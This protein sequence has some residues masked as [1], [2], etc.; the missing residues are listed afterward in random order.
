MTSP[1][2]RQGTVIEFD[3]HV[4]LGRVEDEDGCTYMFHCTQIADG[5]RTIEVGA[6]VTFVVV[7]RWKGNEA[8]DVIGRS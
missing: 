6:A 1:P 8:Y 7:S 4:G 5:R 2:R 3:D